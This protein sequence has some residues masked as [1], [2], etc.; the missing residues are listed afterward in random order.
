MGK[1][2][3]DYYEV[4]GVPRDASKEEI[5]RAYR[6]LALKYH[7]DRNKDDPHA[8]EKFKEISEAYE[9]LSDDEK[10][11]IYD[12]YGHAGL[13]GTGFDAEAI[14]PFQ[15]FNQIFND[16]FGFGD[17]FQNFFGGGS[18]SRVFQQ[19]Q[20]RPERGQD[21]K[22]EVTISL[23]E[24][25][26]GTSRRVKFPVRITC[27]EC[28]GS[29]LKS[30][31]TK[32]TC[33]DCGG[34]GQRQFVQRTAFGIMSQIT[35]CPSCGGL[36]EIIRKGDECS[37]C[38][39]EGTIRDERIVKVNIPAGVGD[40]MLNRLAGQGKPGRYGGPPGDLYILIHVKDHPIFRRNGNDLYVDCPITLTQALLGDEIEVPLPDGTIERIK[41]PKGVQPDET[42]RLKRKGFPILRSDGRSEGRGDLYVQFKIRMPRKL[43][44]TA[45]KLIEQLHQELGNY[46]EG[47]EPYKQYLERVKKNRKH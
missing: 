46:I 11:R 15:I 1:E 35:T 37:R 10:R 9:V 16:L 45:R 2:K 24:A 38:N 4:L 36:G 43:G 3:R 41:I 29:G 6:K 8:E 14:D 32:I 31:R 42:I 23:E 33:P 27:P 17:P 30:G 5:R 28:G 19:Q 13:E 21:V 22:L 12:Q 40:N 26:T 39:G 44:K 34:T 20:Q 7:P 18:R 47:N 25:Y